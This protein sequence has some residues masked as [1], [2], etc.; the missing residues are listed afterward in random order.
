MN[1]L[2]VLRIIF[3]AAAHQDISCS[4]MANVCLFLVVV[5]MRVSG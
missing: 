1:I 4:A 3:F 2:N 5:R